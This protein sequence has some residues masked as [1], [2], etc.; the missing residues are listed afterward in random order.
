MDTEYNPPID[1]SHTQTEKPFCIKHTIKNP[2]FFVIE[3]F[4]LTISLITTKK[5]IICF[6]IN[7]TLYYFLTIIF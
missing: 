3:K 4:L 2:N 6:L 7:V 1:F 5:N